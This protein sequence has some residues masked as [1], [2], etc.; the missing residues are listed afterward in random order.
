[1]KFIIL[2]LT[3]SVAFSATL[4]GVVSTASAGTA[5]WTNATT[6]GASTCTMTPSIVFSG[7]VFATDK[8][9]FTF[10][11]TAGTT[12][13]ASGDTGITCVT[14][15]TTT[16]GTF[17]TAP[18]CSTATFSSA[19]IR[20]GVTSLTTTQTASITTVASGTPLT[21]TAAGPLSAFPTMWNSTLNAALKKTFIYADG[22]TSFVATYTFS[23]AAATA[24]AATATE[25]FAMTW[26]GDFT[27]CETG[28]KSFWKS[29]TA[30]TSFLSGLLALSFF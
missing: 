14:T 16:D 8:F 1:M 24:A 7:L 2:A 13:V 10:M 6:V 9:D 11:L 23:A 30:A 27:A 28:A 4:S 25:Y 26:T 20:T 19:L 22:A 5:T 17:A 18:T 3:L 15:A 29:E 21:F 12:V